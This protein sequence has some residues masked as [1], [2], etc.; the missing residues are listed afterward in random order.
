MVGTA[1]TTKAIVLTDEGRVGIGTTQPTAKLHV[2]A[3]NSDGII[4]YDSTSGT[5]RASLINFENTGGSM[6]L[7]DVDGN[8]Q[9]R[10]RGYAYNGIQAYFTAGKVGIGT[11]MPSTNLEVV[12]TVMAD[13]LMLATAAERYYAIPHHQFHSTT[14]YSRTDF[15]TY[16]NSASSSVTFEA[17]V[18]L[19]HGA[20]ITQFKAAMGDTIAGNVTLDLR[21]YSFTGS[22]W[23]IAQVTSNGVGLTMDSSAISPGHVVDNESRAYYIKATWWTPNWGGNYNPNDT[24]IR[25]ARVKYT[26]DEPLP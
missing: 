1:D 20:S 10:I 14:G 21:A 18:H 11:N 8:A 22:W 3:P 24:Y 12:G 13:T 26:V 15:N 2:M 16:S 17:P 5:Y 19:P 7:N 23:Q 4:M 25:G 6:F 9:A